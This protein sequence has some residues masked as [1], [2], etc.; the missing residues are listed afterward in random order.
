MRYFRAS[1]ITILAAL[2][3]CVP[4]F[5]HAT[6]LFSSQ[7][8]KAAFLKTLSEKD[9]SYDTVEK[10]IRRPFSSPGYHTTLKGGYVHPTRDSLQYAVAL[11]D[12]GDPN[13]A[14]RAQDILRKVIS[15]QDQ[16][17]NSRTYGIWPWFL[18]EPLEKMSPPDWNWADFCG[19]Q[20]L[21]VALDHTHRLPEDLQRKVKD[22]ILHAAYSIK[23][24]NVGPG[25]T[26]IAIMGTYVTV[27]AGELFNVPELADYGK[28][29]LARFYDYTIEHGS[30]TEYNSPTYTVV[31]IK[32]ISRMLRHIKNPDS[33]KLLRELSRL[34]WRH[35][36]GRFHPPTRQ[37][38]GPHSRCY[39]TLLGNDT[40][41]FI[42][43]ATNHKVRFM[44]ETAALES[45]DAHRL[46]A[47]CPPDLLGYFT[48]LPAPRLEI[49]TFQKNAPSGHDI[50]GTTY[51]HPDFT[52][53]SVNIG[54]LW[55]Q[56]RPLLAY[57]KTDTGV[58][59]MRIRCLHDNYDYASA[60]IFAIQDK[61]DIMSAI[62]FA[63]DR[64]D[65]HISLD[66]IENATIKARNLCI[67]LQFEGAIADLNLPSKVE[68][69]CP[70]H[71]SS[72][73][74]N[75]DFQI[76]HATFDNYPITTEAGRDSNTAWLD[77]IFYSGPQKTIDF[78][79]LN[80]AAFIFALSV[81]S[82]AESQ[83]PTHFSD[84]TINRK[85]NLITA[86]WSRPSGRP[87]SQM[88]LTIP[89]KPDSSSRQ[90]I[91]SSAKLGEQNPWKGPKHSANST[92]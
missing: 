19:V 73:P 68:I 14:A 78:R 60:S 22:S 80:E 16:D 34:A 44:P 20:L 48:D 3:L 66:R 62:V 89:A 21:Q 28:A 39:S 64:G 59:A 86:N 11:L 50:I 7:E 87:N 54:D 57:W 85:D 82:L 42:Q 90:R 81:N 74:V 6:E 15:L 31:A 55:N 8:Q 83:G 37:W 29:R 47:Q 4:S 53:G 88:S 79:Q 41:A 35:L 40:L 12:W 56:R 49:E 71:I 76:A 1:I 46:V 24:R 84:L 52:L 63:T 51:L 2:C 26:D 67:R 36:A 69:G 30:F 23:R 5:C 70:I 9:S 18:E 10:V 75:V 77:I 17:P 13:R 27:V 25:Y 38:S 32:E 43:R 65:T 61:S 45:I 91:N 92:F 58:A 33:Q 72:G